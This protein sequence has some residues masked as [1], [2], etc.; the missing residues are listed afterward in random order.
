ME[1][2]PPSSGSCPATACG[3]LGGLAGDPFPRLLKE[4]L[5][6]ERSARLLLL[7]PPPLPGALLWDLWLTQRVFLLC[8]FPF[9][10]LI[11]AEKMG[12]EPGGSPFT[13]EKMAL[14]NWEERARRW[15]GIATGQAPNGEPGHP[16]P[17]LHRAERCPPG[18][19]LPTPC[20][21]ATRS[22]TGRPNGHLPPPAPASAGLSTQRRGCVTCLLPTWLL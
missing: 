10:A 8:C 19:L 18:P 20:P 17:Y 14:V 5:L 15:W 11:L 13:P 3:G 16:P 9:P 21:P 4:P 22:Q 2:P 6:V 1:R 7:L 12:M